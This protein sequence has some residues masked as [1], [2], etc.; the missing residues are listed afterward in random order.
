MSPEQLSDLVREYVGTPEQ[1]AKAELSLT[2]RH[3]VEVERSV[4]SICWHYPEYLGVVQQKLNPKTHFTVPAYRIVLEALQLQ[5]EKCGAADWAGVLEVVCE[6]GGLEECGGLEGL[7]DIFTDH[8]RNPEGPRADLA[9]PILSDHVRFL[10]EAAIQRGVDPTQP[11]RHYTSGRGFLQKNKA[12][13]KPTH[14]TAVGEAYV[15]GHKFKL[16]GWPAGDGVKLKMELV[17]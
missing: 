4:V 14:P 12:A 9:E 17:R 13:T 7:N 15:L 10:K 5:N 3:T 16:L 11:V 6:L 8:N 1:L 2:L